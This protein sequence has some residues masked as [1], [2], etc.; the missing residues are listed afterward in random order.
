MLVTGPGRPPF[1]TSH[2]VAGEE[3]IAVWD[4]HPARNVVV[5]LARP[6]RTINSE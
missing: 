2:L 6:L 4:E 1:T 5:G 3:T